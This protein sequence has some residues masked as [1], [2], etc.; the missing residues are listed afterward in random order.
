MDPVVRSIIYKESFSTPREQQSSSLSHTGLISD[1]TTLLL[2]HQPGMGL[3]VELWNYIISFLKLEPYPLL[4]CCLTCR[5]F[6]EHAKGKL[7]TL[8]ATIISLHDYNDIDNLVKDIR[9]IAGRARPI[10]ALYLQDQRQSPLVFSLVPHRLAIQ[11]VNLKELRISRIHEA[12]IVPSSTWSLYGHA[13]PSVEYLDVWAVRFPSFKDLVHFVVSFRA[14]KKLVLSETS[15]ARPGIPLRSLQFPRTTDI[16]LV[17]IQ[18]PSFNDFL[19]FLTSFHALKVLDVRSI[20]F[21]HPG[22]LLKF[23]QFPDTITLDFLSVRFPSFE[24]FLYFVTLFRV[25]DKLSLKHISFAHPG[26]PHRSLRT[27]STLR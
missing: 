23:P 24:D 16:T 26:V 4:A 11:L 1:A 3:P 25:F 9:A 20:S 2:S 17:E 27:S 5:N 18:F 21:A 10:R 8:Y 6:L 7:K 13:F 14:L 22:A 15:F 12:P 19:H